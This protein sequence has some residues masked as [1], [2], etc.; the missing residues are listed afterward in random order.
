MILEI[1]FLSRD[2]KYCDLGCGVPQWGAGVQGF[3]CSCFKL[4][5]QV[6]TGILDKTRTDKKCFGFSKQHVKYQY[7]DI[8]PYAIQ[9]RDTYLEIG[10]A[11]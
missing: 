8:G 4:P 2:L 9:S 1:F 11:L 5:L 10:Q 3:V 6:T 7:T